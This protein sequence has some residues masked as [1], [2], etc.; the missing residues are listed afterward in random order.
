MGKTDTGVTKGEMYAG[1]IVN[2]PFAGVFFVM[3]HDNEV[4]FLST[5]LAKKDRYM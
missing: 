3:N 4:T 5:K 2:S 1:F